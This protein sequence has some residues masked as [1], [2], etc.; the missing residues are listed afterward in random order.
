M[1]NLKEYFIKQTGLYVFNIYLTKLD[2]K[3]EG[4]KLDDNIE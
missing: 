2:L 4:L 3:Y 1:A